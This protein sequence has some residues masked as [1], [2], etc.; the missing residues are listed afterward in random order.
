[1]LTVR[2]ASPVFGVRATLRGPHGLFIAQSL[3]AERSRHSAPAQLLAR[4]KI[5]QAIRSTRF[6]S[7]DY[8]GDRTLGRTAVVETPCTSV[9]GRRRLLGPEGS[10]E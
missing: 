9:S 8:R 2:V 5:V 3:V 10:G 6:F 1:M 4:R 7:Y